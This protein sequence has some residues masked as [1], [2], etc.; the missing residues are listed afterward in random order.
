[1]IKS[2]VAVIVL[3]AGL[4]TRMKSKKPKVLHSLG[5]R[6]MIN[7]LMETVTGLDPDEVVVVVGDS[8]DDVSHAVSPFPTAVQS[9]RLGTAHAVLAARE[10]ILDFDGVWQHITSRV[11]SCNPAFTARRIY[12]AVSLCFQGPTGSATSM[13]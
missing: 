4:G 8:M 7:H 10:Y 11:C 13:A 3:A 12:L 2:K 5:C 1:M 6:P 9:E